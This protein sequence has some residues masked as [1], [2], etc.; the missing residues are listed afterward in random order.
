MLLS[1]KQFVA[2]TAAISA[3][4]LAANGAADAQGDPE[5]APLHFHILKESEYDHAALVG[6]LQ[7]PHKNKQ[8]FQASDARVVAPGIA[9]LYIHMQNS[10]NAFEF[11]YPKS[12]GPLATVGVVMAPAMIFALNDA[13]WEKYKF[14]AAFNLAPSNIYYRATSKLDLGASP[15]DPASIYQDWSAQA[16]LKRGGKF[17]VCH[18]ATMAVA[19]MTAAKAGSTPSAV[20]ADF[21]ANL[22]PGFAFVPAGVAAVQLAVEHGWGLFQV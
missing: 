13:M 1:R 2:S 6:A 8:V 5:R 18:N 10:M 22:L 21:K 16:I 4:A 17:F 14:G 19:A 15:D 12:T 11:S 20:L 9:S 3:S 7:A